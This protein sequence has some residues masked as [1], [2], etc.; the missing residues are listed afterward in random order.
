MQFQI[1][2]FRYMIW[3]IQVNNLANTGIRF[4]QYWYT[5]SPIP[6]NDFVNT[7]KG[8]FSQIWADLRSKSK[9]WGVLEICLCNQENCPFKLRISTLRRH[10]TF[11]LECPVLYEKETITIVCLHNL[12]RNKGSDCEGEKE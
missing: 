6:L 11:F 2:G 9:T 12:I 1:R 10:K 3:S 7:C 4:R 5:I 8:T